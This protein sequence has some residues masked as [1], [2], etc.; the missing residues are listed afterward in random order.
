MQD[1]QTEIDSQR[2]VYTSLA[3]G[4]QRLGAGLDSA[5]EAAMLQ[6]RLDQMNHRWNYL[7]NRAVAIKSV[8][9]LLCLSVKPAV[10][11][12]Y[13]AYSRDSEG[14]FRIYYLIFH[15]RE[16]MYCTASRKELRFGFLL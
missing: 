14:D 10:F 16:P 4:G 5:E 6:C 1:L 11:V 9:S 15:Q 7:K 13:D 3:A 2:D 8:N 12:G